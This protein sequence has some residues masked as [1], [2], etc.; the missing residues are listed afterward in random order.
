VA[1]ALLAYRR[2]EGSVAAPA[3]GEGPST[4]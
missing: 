3:P 4:A 2:T 1:P